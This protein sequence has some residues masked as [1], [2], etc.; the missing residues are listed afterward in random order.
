M[1]GRFSWEEVLRV[2]GWRSEYVSVDR[3]LRHLAR[4]T[5]S[6]ASRRV[7]LKTLAEF[8]RFT[9]LSPDELVALGREEVEERVQAFCDLVRTPRTA[10]RKMEELKTFFKC[11]GFRVGNRCSLV[12]ERRYVGA[13]H[14]S[15]AEYIP[16]DEEIYRMV[17]ESGLSLKWR[18]FLLTLYTTGL[19]NSTARA[20][21]VGDVWGELKAGVTPLLMRVYPEMK[22]VVPEACKGNLPYFTFMPRE[23]VD[24]LKAYLEDREERLGPIKEDQVLYCSDNRRIPRELRAY[25]PLDISAVTRMVKRAAKMAGIEEWRHVTPHS[26]RKAYERALRN[27]G[28]DLK[29]QEFLMGH[30]LPR[31]QDTYYDKTKVEELRAKYAKVEFFPSIRMPMEELRRRQIIDMVR[32]L[33][34]PEDKIKRVEE[35]LAKYETV[36]E[37][38][39]EIRKLS[40]EGYKVREDVNSDPKKI[41]D[42]DELEKYLADGWDVQMV[43]PSGR[44][45]IRRI[46]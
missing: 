36:D 27:S 15:R 26:L 25:T 7:Y 42:E 19:R 31:S 21:R 22:R 33:G 9:G 24:A 1:G 39:E 46:Q 12:L 13:R 23:A 37:A 2:D 28:L 8:V 17:N 41:V 32:L 29:D 45:L 30:I 14:R 43:L 4:R 16:T 6:E 44:I 10:N 20:L 35:A 40:L 34:F 18:S 5:G 38:M 11:N 3:L